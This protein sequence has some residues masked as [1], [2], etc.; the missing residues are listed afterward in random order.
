M[1]F[2]PHFSDTLSDLVLMSDERYSDL[3]EVGFFKLGQVLE[4]TVSGLYKSVSV[5]GHLDTL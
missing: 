2:L 3:F 5:L 1:E 4:I